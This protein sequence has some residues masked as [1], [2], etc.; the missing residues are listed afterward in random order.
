[1]FIWRV[2]K[3]ALMISHLAFYCSLPSDGVARVAVK[4][5]IVRDK[6]ALRQC[7]Q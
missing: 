4:G 7:P 5:L 2:Q 1:M 6:V 3:K